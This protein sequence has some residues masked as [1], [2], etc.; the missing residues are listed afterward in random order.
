VDHVLLETTCPTPLIIRFAIGNYSEPPPFVIP[1]DPEPHPS[2]YL[3]QRSSATAIQLSSLTIMSPFHPPINPE[4]SEPLPSR[5]YLRRW[6][7][8]VA[9]AVSSWFASGQSMWSLWWTKWHWDRFSPSAS[10]TPANH[11]STNFSIIIIIRGWHNRPIG[12]RSAEWAQ[13]DSTPHYTS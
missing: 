10:V 11:R 7:R 6:G 9:K 2:S 4:E 5:Y 13:L 8:A 12:G 1:N 3:L